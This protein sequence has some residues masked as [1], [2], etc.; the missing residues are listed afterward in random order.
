MEKEYE[1]EQVPVIINVP[2]NTVKLNVKATVMEDDNSLREA[3]MTMNTAQVM[4]A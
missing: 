4:K 2:D 1:C 3:E